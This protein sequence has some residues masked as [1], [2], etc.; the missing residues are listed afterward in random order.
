MS[1]PLS[2]AVAIEAVACNFPRCDFL[3]IFYPYSAGCY[4]GYPK[5]PRMI[6]GIIELPVVS[7]PPNLCSSVVPP[8]FPFWNLSLGVSL[9]LGFWSLELRF[10]GCA[11]FRFLP[12]STQ[13]NNK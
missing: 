5:I 3:Q 7:G 10:L 8:L 6:L 1:A 9:E 13:T 2:Q 12:I 11:C 4:R